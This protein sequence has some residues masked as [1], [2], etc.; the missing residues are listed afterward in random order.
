MNEASLHWRRPDHRSVE[1]AGEAGRVVRRVRD[2]RTIDT[3][4]AVPEKVRGTENKKT[5]RAGFILRSA[6]LQEVV[7]VVENQAGLVLVRDTCAARVVTT[8]TQR[9]T[10]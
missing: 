6:Q 5:R 7:G 8:C 2:S 3:S 9:R 10:E 1:P 4:R